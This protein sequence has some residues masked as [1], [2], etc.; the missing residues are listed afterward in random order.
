MSYLTPDYLQLRN[1]NHLRGHSLITHPLYESD[2]KNASSCLT[3]FLNKTI[4][5]QAR[6]MRHA[7]L[8][9]LSA[10]KCFNNSVNNYSASE[11]L[12]C[13]KL[14]FRKDPILN[15]I[16]DFNKHVDA[17]LIDQYEKKLQGVE[18]AIEYE[19]K[20][21]AFLLETN[22]LSRYYFYFIAKDLFTKQ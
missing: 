8:Y 13:E 18:C 22:Y 3:N 10:E 6:F 16:E 11:S 4:L 19:T 17:T 1:K 2:L 20:H 14:L 5:S 7:Y 12:E 9:N 21:K 15:N